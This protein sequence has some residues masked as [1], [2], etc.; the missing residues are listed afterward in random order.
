MGGGICPFGG[1]RPGSSSNT[2]F[3]LIHPTIWP[4]YSNVTDRQTNR[5]TT[6]Q[7][8]RQR[9]DSIGRTVLG[10]LFLRRFAL[11]YRTVV[12]PVCLSRPKPQKGPSLSPI[13]GL[14][15]ILKRSPISAT[16]EQLYKRSPKNQ[17]VMSRAC[18]YTILV[19][20]NNT[21]I[22]RTEIFFQWRINTRNYSSFR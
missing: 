21:C 3:I 22:S 4:Q 15:P 19:L 1:G 18:F 16:A 11:Y 2:S 17:N 10:R 7:T 20:H 13:I 6:R 12:C 8:D 9:S 5:Q 14:C